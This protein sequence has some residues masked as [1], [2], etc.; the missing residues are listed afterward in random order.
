M[1]LPLVPFPLSLCLTNCV[2]IISKNNCHNS[3]IFP[4]L[5]QPRKSKNTNGLNLMKTSDFTNLL[6][7]L[8]HFFIDEQ[9]LKYFFL[10]ITSFKE[11]RLL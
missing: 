3:L 9:L 5:I 6:I 10:A 11:K 2:I 8:D 1:N 7:L 4:V